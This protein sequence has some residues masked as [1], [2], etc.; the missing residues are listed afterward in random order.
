M[1]ATMNKEARQT[2]VRTYEGV[3]WFKEAGVGDYDA[4]WR[5][6]VP[7]TNL[8][9]LRWVD[10]TTG[11]KT[12]NGWFCMVEVWHEGTW[13]SWWATVMTDRD[14]RSKDTPFQLPWDMIHS[15]TVGHASRDVSVLRAHVARQLERGVGA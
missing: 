5:C 3:Q 4:F 10:T 6:S 15:P 13:S 12:G 7:G 2:T 1:A 11:P 8:S 14:G 9:V